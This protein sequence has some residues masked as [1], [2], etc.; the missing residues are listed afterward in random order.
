MSLSFSWIS[1][2]SMDKNAD[3]GLELNKCL[4]TGAIKLRS[5]EI[6]VPVNKAIILL[7]NKMLRDDGLNDL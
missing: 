3:A 1:A 5:K 4:A 6:P 7:K 2:S